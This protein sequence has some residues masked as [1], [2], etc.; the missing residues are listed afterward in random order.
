MNFAF[1][2]PRIVDFHV[3]M[4]VVATA[5]SPP[6][7]PIIINVISQTET[8]NLAMIGAV[9]TAYQELGKAY[10]KATGRQT[11]Q[12]FCK[13][14]KPQNRSNQTPLPICQGGD[15]LKVLVYLT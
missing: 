1:A 12:P 9:V 2:R 4:Q 14:C 5:E 11:G 6:I 8:D 13:L 15:A 10:R 3:Q 7:R